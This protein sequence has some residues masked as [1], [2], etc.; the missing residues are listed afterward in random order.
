M[1]H[2]ETS[3]QYAFAWWLSQTYPEVLFT[4][5]LAGV[6][7][8]MIAALRVRRMGYR[9]GTPDILI[10]EPRGCYHGLFLE[11][12]APQGKPSPTQ[13]QFRDSLIARDY[14]CE[15]AYGLDEAQSITAEYLKGGDFSGKSSQ[16][17]SKEKN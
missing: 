8:S 9:S 10:F 16:E 12:K 17:S 14:K 13:R 1:K 11:L 4:T 6:N 15:F 7:L 3:I 5:S 2:R